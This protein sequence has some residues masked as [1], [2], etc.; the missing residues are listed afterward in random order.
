M[1]ELARENNPT[2]V[3]SIM[4]CRN[5]SNLVKTYDAIICGFA[6]PYLTKEDTIQPIKDASKRLSKNGV[7]F[8]STMEDDYSKSG[9]VSSSQ[10]DQMFIHFHEAS[11]LKEALQNNNLEIIDLRRK[12]YPG[13][14]G[15]PVTDLLILKK[16]SG[17]PDY[18]FF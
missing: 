4:D 14:D 2:A 15:K 10:G 13:P 17:K 6:L 9:L 18:H 16:W 5:I 1:L 7:L 3:F 11:Y 8:I 12:Q